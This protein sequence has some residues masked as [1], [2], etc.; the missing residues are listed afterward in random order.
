MKVEDFSISELGYAGEQIIEYSKKIPNIIVKEQFVDIKDDVIGMKVAVAEL[1]NL[2]EQ[3][4]RGN[5]ITEIYVDRHKKLLRDLYSY[6][7]NIV[8]IIIPK[9]TE[10]IMV[11]EQK[12]KISSLKTLLKNNKDFVS[13]LL[14]LAIIVIQI[15]KN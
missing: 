10:Q 2:Q 8:D 3:F 14:Q 13:N 1:Q 5:I 4:D 15:F 6:R 11:E 9:I 7:D 12:S